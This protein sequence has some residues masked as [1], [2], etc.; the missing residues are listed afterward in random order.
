M[1]INGPEG[2]RLAVDYGQYDLSAAQWAK[3]ND[4][5][6]R[7]LKPIYWKNFQAIYQVKD[8]LSAEK[9]KPLFNVFSLLSPSAYDFS[10]AMKKNDKPQARQA[11]KSLL[12][13]FPGEDYWREQLRQVR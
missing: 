8:H 6:A 7:G 2:L 3:V 13:L 11:L 12:T 10:Q 4:L 5:V 9:T 1:A